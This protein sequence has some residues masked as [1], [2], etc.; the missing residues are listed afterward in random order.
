MSLT[1][2]QIQAGT[3]MLIGLRQKLLAMGAQLK[4]THANGYCIVHEVT[5]RHGTALAAFTV[6][7]AYKV[8]NDILFTDK[9]EWQIE[10]KKLQ[11]H[12]ANSKATI[13]PVAPEVVG[14]DAFEQ[15]KRAG[16]AADAQAKA[17]EESIKAAKSL[18][19]AYLPTKSTSRGQSIDYA[20]QGLMQGEWTK[21][22][23]EAI[24]Q[25]RNL[26]EHVKS[27]AAAI[28]KRY[29]LRETG[30]TREDVMPPASS[31]ETRRDSFGSGASFRE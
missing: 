5:K 21:A 20:D 4:D 8:V 19:A 13:I 3:S 14:S 30:R 9:L 6:E 27:L 11:A 1:P 10:P 7:N 25:K 29:Q 15:K 17:D 26:Q 22:L 28:Q 18:I 2:E 12:K 31:S 23:N 24:A 16:E